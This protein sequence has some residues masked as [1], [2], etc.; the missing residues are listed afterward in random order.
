MKNVLGIVRYD[1]IA[2][3]TESLS[4]FVQTE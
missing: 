2:I 4:R 1:F 3:L